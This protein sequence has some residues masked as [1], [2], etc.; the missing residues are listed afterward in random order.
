MELLPAQCRAARA[1]LNWS[2][3]QLEAASQVAKKT[4]ADFEREARTPYPRTLTAIRSAFE[5][6]GLEFTDHVGNAGVRFSRRW[7]IIQ[8]APDGFVKISDTINIF[9]EPSYETKLA[10][11]TPQGTMPVHSPPRHGEYIRTYAKPGDKGT[12]VDIRR[13]TYDDAEGGHY[14]YVAFR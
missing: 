6:E 8:N 5:K 2:Q 14:D 1:L 10:I 4:I 3:S 13:K 12:V 9:E 7:M 11:T